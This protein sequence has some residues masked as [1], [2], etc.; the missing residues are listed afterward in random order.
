MATIDDQLSY[1]VIGFAMEAHRELGPGLDEAFYHD[2]MARR[3]T[4][5]GIAHQV[6]P[7]GQ[8]VHRGL[9][10]DEFEA[11]L[12]V[13]GT[14]AAEL[15]VLWAGFAP[16]HLL[17]IICYLKFWRLDAGLLFDFNKESL[18]QKRVPRLDRPMDFD[19]AVFRRA[20]P[21][22]P[23]AS[24]LFDQITEGMRVLL[25]EHGL[26]YRD[27]TYRGLLFAELAHRKI[28]C[29]RD[30]V[31]A[32][33]SAGGALGECKLPCLV[34]PGEGAL[35]VTALRESRQAADRAVLQAYVRH[36]DLPWGLHLNF[37]KHRLD[38]QSVSNQTLHGK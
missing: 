11:D 36:L 21:S 30:P 8:L 3:L 1:A 18:A 26:G 9:V 29:V 35:L 32:I 4:T 12:I 28:P 22:F 5:A 20:L 37:G 17:Q 7:R 14:L 15:K 16:E 19:P 31:A 34:L 23:G 6:K 33:R 27:T 13:A 24:V 25:T 38:F 2:L 10:A